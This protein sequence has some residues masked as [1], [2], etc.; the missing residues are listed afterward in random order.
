VQPVSRLDFVLERPSRVTVWVNGVAVTTLALAAGRHDLRDLPLGAGVNDIELVVVDDRGGERRLVFTSINP[1]TLLA[2]GVAPF[3][4]AIGFPRVD[5]GYARRY[6][7]DRPIVSARRRWGV[8]EHLTVGGLFDADLQLQVAG[9]ELVLATGLGTF[10]VDLSASHESAAGIDV[11][12]RVRYDLVRPGAAPSSVTAIVVHRGRGFRDLGLS[13]TPLAREEL[14][15]AASRRLFGRTFVRAGARYD[16]LHDRGG[17]AEASLALSCPFAGLSVDASFSVRAGASAAAE[18]RGLVGLRWS[19]PADGVAL[20]ASS[21]VSRSDGVAWQLGYNQTASTPSGGLTTSTTLQG[22]PQAIDAS[23]S[24]DYTNARLSA[25]LTGE[26]TYDRGLD[27]TRQRA[28][29]ALASALVFADGRFGWSRPVTGSFALVV[30]DDALGDHPVGVNPSR[31]GSMATVDRWGPAV[32]PNLEAYRLGR[33]QVEAPELAPGTSLGP[34]SYLLLPGYKSGTL[35]RVGE[36]GTVVVRGQLRARDG[37]P[38]AMVTGEIVALGTPGA[39]P[40]IL[41]TNRRGRFATAGLSPGLHEIRLPGAA[42]KVFDIPA[43]FV[44][45]RSLGVLE[46]D[47]GT[48]LESDGTEK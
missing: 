13:G 40:K 28:G 35:I 8:T 20:R 18:V 26:T 2:P 17:S 4:L 19:L 16:V 47:V 34:G 27:E 6:R 5:D 14:V 32:V 25:S 11:A 48:D 30:A 36:P 41:M 39:A 42:V 10:S 24:L 33:V 23:S 31:G 38:L 15:L 29:F 37:A 22:Q 1:A 7:F 12:T 21:R 3:S 44:G 46:I 9:A 45:V 43:G